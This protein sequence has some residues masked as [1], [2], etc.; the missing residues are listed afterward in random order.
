[1]APVILSH[2]FSAGPR[3]AP[4]GLGVSLLFLPV[5]PALRATGAATGDLGPGGGDRQAGSQVGSRRA[6]GAFALMSGGRRMA[7]LGSICARGKR[8]ISERLSVLLISLVPCRAALSCPVTVFL[9]L[10]PRLLEQ[11]PPAPA[12]EE[13]NRDLRQLH[14][15]IRGTQYSSMMKLLRLALSGQ[16]VGPHPKSWLSL[17][18]VTGFGQL[19]C[20]PWFYFCKGV[21]NGAPATDSDG[22]TVQNRRG[23]S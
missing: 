7:S 12:P 14:G 22:M 3:E 1:M 17:W 20:T 8:E 19:G 9:L 5:D 2:P 15:Q 11:Q 10:L 18:W 16:Q 4:E 6:W 21:Q 13:L 23:C